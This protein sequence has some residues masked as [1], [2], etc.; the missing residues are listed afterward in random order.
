MNRLE[1]S[2]KDLKFNIDVIKKTVIGKDKDD[3]GNKIK[4]IAVVKAN[5]M[6]LG[7]V[8]FSKF[9][10]NNGIHTLAVSRVEE[11]VELRLAKI[12]AEILML[13]PVSSEKDI[14]T[15]LDNKIILSV[16]SLS[17]FEKIE[18]ILEKR[19]EEA[20]C[21]IKIDTGLGCCKNWFRFSRA[22]F[23]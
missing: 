19:E 16:G 4:I 13:S 14:N 20:S 1:I 18:E 9:V 3:S 7:I 23:A 11:A 12:D 5:A 22:N 17:E 15:L 2:K 10:I 21:H 6:G 8:E